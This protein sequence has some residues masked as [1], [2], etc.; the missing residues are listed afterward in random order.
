MGKIAIFILFIVSSLSLFGQKLEKFKIIGIVV[1]SVSGKPIE[2]ATISIKTKTGFVAL[3]IVNNE[4]RF[5]FGELADGSY[6]LEFSAY[7]YNSKI[8]NSIVVSVSEKSKDVGTILL[9]AKVI[10]LNEVKVEGANFRQYIDKDVF[11][12]DQNKFTNGS[13]ST[14]VLKRINGLSVTPGGDVKVLG[15]SD[16]KI[17]V[18][19]RSY[20]LSYIKSLPASSIKSIEVISIALPKYDAE[21]YSSVINIITMKNLIDGYNG[22]VYARIGTRDIFGTGVSARVKSGK[23]SLDAY[24]DYSS[25]LYL[26]DYNLITTFKD[27]IIDKQIGKRTNDF[28]SHALTTNF[29]FNLDTLNTINFSVGVNRSKIN[30]QSTTDY[31]TT[32]TVLPST[33]NS[34]SGNA[35]DNYRLIAEY[36]HVLSKKKLDHSLTTTGYY[37]KNNESLEQ[38]IDQITSSI[39]NNNINN[40]YSDEFIAQVDYNLPVD[41]KKNFDAGVKFI[42]RKSLSTYA[43]LVDENDKNGIGPG[44]G[45][46]GEVDYLQKIEAAYASY[47]ANLG[48]MSFLL[49]GRLESTRLNTQGTST[50]I[51][52]NF[53]NFFPSIALSKSWKQFGRLK[54][55]YSR[56]IARPGVGYINPFV[57]TR[58]PNNI[59]VGNANLRPEFGNAI[60][61]THSKRFRNMFILTSLR[62][63]TEVD[64]IQSYV[65][66]SQDIL[67]TQ[68]QNIGS[69]TAYTVGTSI[70]YDFTEKF[71][72]SLSTF[73]NK[74]NNYDRLLEVSTSGYTYSLDGTLN[75]NLGK[76]YNLDASVMY[77]SPKL[78]PQGTIY[79]VNVIEASVNKTFDKNFSINVIASDITNSLGLTRKNTTTSSGIYQ[80]SETR[81]NNRAFKISA[82]YSFGKD[83]RVKRLSR[84]VNNNDLKELGK[85]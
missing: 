70:S 53:L 59:L 72:M 77:A 73:M 42:R 32:S 63:N 11:I 13:R 79:G 15:K 28:S 18:N 2:H 46:A 50:S 14:D 85:Q 81:F 40:I 64:L 41:S 55:N 8:I 76:G 71:S 29:L 48:F 17:L 23:V 1:D 52:Q 7:G 33:I 47:N 21:G 51:D 22:D 67:I 45:L 30:R 74:V 80:I 39:N 84:K 38:V 75:L 69:K 12:I 61:L 43:Y 36:K 56:N 31:I 20:D 37:K 26:G 68:Y 57:D 5:I 49:G 25:Y 9:S 65:Y 6:Q 58:D 34:T 78:T 27:N 10:D 19:G 62:Y 82:F 16:P 3:G 44:G 4:G 24:Y 54:L 83:F 60:E 66:P 35:Y